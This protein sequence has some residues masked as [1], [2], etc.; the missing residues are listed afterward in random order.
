MP[1][2]SRRKRV[3]RFKLTLSSDCATYSEL[4]PQCDAVNEVCNFKICGQY[5]LGIPNVV[6]DR[7]YHKL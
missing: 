7:F 2:G 4:P 3:V 5:K 6:L 1:L